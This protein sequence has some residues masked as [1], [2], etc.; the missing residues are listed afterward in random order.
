MNA[1]DDYKLKNMGIGFTNIVARTSR[2]SADLSK[3]VFYA[4]QYYW[5]LCCTMLIII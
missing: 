4:K 5:G 2:G 1:Y 3:F